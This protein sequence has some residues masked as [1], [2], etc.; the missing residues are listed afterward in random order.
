MRNQ[1][2]IYDRGSSGAALGKI[3][4]Q[5]RVKWNRQRDTFSEA[6][7]IGRAT[8]PD[9]CSLMERTRSVRH[10]LVIE[11][12]GK[13]VWEGPITGISLEKEGTYKISARDLL[14]FPNRTVVKNTYSSA[15]PA[16]RHVTEHAEEVIRG[17]MAAGEAYGFNVLPGLEVYTNAETSNTSAVTKPYSGY[18][19]DVLDSLAQRSSL[20]YVVVNRRLILIDTHQ[21]IAMG[22]RLVDADFL[23]GLRVTEYGVELAVGNY[24]SGTEDNAGVVITEEGLDYYGPIELLAASYGSGSDDA[25]PPTQ[26]EL[27]DQALRNARSRYPAPVV[28]KVPEN[29]QL[30]PSTVDDIFDW[31]IPTTGFPIYSDATCR[32]IEQIQKLDKVSFEE[33]AD[34]EKVSVTLSSAPIGSDIVPED[35]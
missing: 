3:D 17:E 13:R 33:T 19:W 10:E 29:S 34:G 7:V 8:A 22:R 21:F 16:I 30:A 28:L 24:V 32:E 4:G 27:D 25:E 12:D 20:D 9:C 2:F 26:E 14:F 11:R 31:L 6:E 35:E 23:D 1:A 18:V 15:Y 5:V